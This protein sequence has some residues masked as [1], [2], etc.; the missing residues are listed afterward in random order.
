MSRCRSWRPVEDR[1]DGH[2]SSHLPPGLPGGCRKCWRPCR[3]R[4]EDG[5]V[6][7]TECAVMLAQH[8][9]EQIRRMLLAE[10]DLPL[11]IIDLLRMDFSAAVSGPAQARFDELSAQRQG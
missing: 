10:D 9:N 5:Q 4:V 11:D 7:C 3:N 2:S 6:R 8:P 1:P